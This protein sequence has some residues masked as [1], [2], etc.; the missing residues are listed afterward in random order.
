MTALERRILA[1]KL[2]SDAREE[3]LKEENDAQW[4]GCFERTVCLITEL[5]TPELDSTI[6]TQGVYID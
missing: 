1:T 6:H 2:I 5:V 4:V 3:I